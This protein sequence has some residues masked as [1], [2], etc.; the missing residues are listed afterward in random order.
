[1]MKIAEY[2]NTGNFIGSSSVVCCGFV[3]D[4]QHTTTINT[5]SVHTCVVACDKEPVCLVAHTVVHDNSVLRTAYACFRVSTLGTCGRLDL[6]YLSVVFPS[7]LCV[8][9]V[10]SFVGFGT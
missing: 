8:S 1:M 4:V 5:C 2:Y 7:P 10:R 6:F 3:T 9:F